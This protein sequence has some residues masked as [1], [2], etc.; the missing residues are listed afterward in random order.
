MVG[1][2]LLPALPHVLSCPPQRAAWSTSNARAAGLDPAGPGPPAPWQEQCGP[3]FLKLQ[4]KQSGKV[5]WEGTRPYISNWQWV[6]YPW[7]HWGQANML[8]TAGKR[9]ARRAKNS[10]SPV[11]IFSNLPSSFEILLTTSNFPLILQYF[12]VPVWPW[13][14]GR[15]PATV[16]GMCT[17]LRCLHSAIYLIW[18]RTSL[19]TCYL[20]I[21]HG[22][23]LPLGPHLFKR[24][25]K[26]Y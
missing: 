3:L 18:R 15:H 21:S 24:S 25:C 23:D 9:K 6:L 10:L 5:L 16:V 20:K 14:D 17:L 2:T 8:L 26:R 12:P 7:A 19:C 11:F 4:P 1:M 13:C 22:P